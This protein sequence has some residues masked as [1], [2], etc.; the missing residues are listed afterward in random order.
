M[1]PSA[2]GGSLNTV[3]VHS[4]VHERYVPAAAR[5]ADLGVL[6]HDAHVRQAR[7]LEP[8]GEGAT[9]E[10]GDDRLEDVRLPRVAHVT[11]PARHEAAHL[12]GRSVRRWPERTDRGQIRAGAERFV[13]RAGQNRDEELIV[14]AESQPGVVQE[15]RGLAVD[16]IALLGA[17]DPDGEDVPFRLCDDLRHGCAMLM[18]VMSSCQRALIALLV[19][20]AC[21]KEAPA[22]SSGRIAIRADDKG[23]TPSSV[24]V[25]KGAPATLVFTRTTNDTCATSVVFPELKIKKDLPLNQPVDVEVPTGDA[26][27]LSFACGM[28]M[29]KSSVVVQ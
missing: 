9:V 12:G 1:A 28:N 29:F 13:A 4:T 26:R 14:V 8:A 6:A 11:G 19:I 15:L 16:A 7:E 17:V 21:N 20:V 25:K 3:M 10:R 2:A 5:D 27:T 18:A 24:T 23:F 22:Q